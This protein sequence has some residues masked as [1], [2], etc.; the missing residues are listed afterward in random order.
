MPDHSAASATDTGSPWAATVATQPP[1][2]R[3]PAHSDT[4]IHQALRQASCGAA[5]CAAAPLSTPKSPPSPLP[6]PLP[7][8][9]LRL[10]KLHSCVGPAWSCA[11][12]AAQTQDGTHLPAL[13][14]RK[15][16]R[17]KPIQQLRLKALRVRHERRWMDGNAR[18]ADRSCGAPHAKAGWLGQPHMHKRCC[19]AGRR[20]APQCHG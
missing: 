1:R 3:L 5:D 15:K 2:Q 9:N 6:T 7:A 19:C 10:N 11:A 4:Q 16:V 8:A 13:V 20:T 14:Q 18:P 12:A 17:V